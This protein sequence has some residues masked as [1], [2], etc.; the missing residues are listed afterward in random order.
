MLT[1]V[2]IYS[3]RFFVPS[4]DTGRFFLAMRFLLSY[5][6]SPPQTNNGKAKNMNKI[7]LT[8]GLVAVT[9]VACKGATTEEKSKEADKSAQAD[10]A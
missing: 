2:A 1:F 10:G 8:L 7:L 4:S 6:L 3:L 5:T 9:F